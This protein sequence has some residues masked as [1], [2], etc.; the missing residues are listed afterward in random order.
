MQDE[1]PPQDQAI[2]RAL[3][4]CIARIDRDPY[5]VLPCVPALTDKYRYDV[6]AGVFARAIILRH[7]GEFL[8]KS[9]P[10]FFTSLI[11]YFPVTYHPGIPASPLVASLQSFHRALYWLNACFPLIALAWLVLLCWRRTGRRYEV[12]A[13]SVIVLLVAYGV[14]VTTL[15]GYR[16]DDFM[17][18][19]I[20]FDPLLIVLFWTS[21]FLLLRY[22]C[23]FVRHQYICRRHEPVDSPDPSARSKSA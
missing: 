4:R 2:S 3:D 6:P 9:L 22:L 20:V 8:L 15:G 18:V 11:D 21:L 14:V 16:P 19:H 17:R 1:A 7:P 12:L 13:M 23:D 5:H 10:L